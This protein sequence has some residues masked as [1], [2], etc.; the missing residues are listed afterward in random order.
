MTP[1]GNVL[2]ILYVLWNFQRCIKKKWQISQF[3]FSNT[4][5]VI[6]NIYLKILFIL[7]V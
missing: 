1:K 4:F 5:Y 6:Q 3:N 2:H 7:N